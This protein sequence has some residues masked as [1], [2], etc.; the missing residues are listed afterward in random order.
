MTPPRSAHARMT[1]SGFALRDGPERPRPGVRDDDRSR[2]LL[3]R[4]ERRPVAGVGDVDDQPE[5][6][7]APDRAPAE[8]GETGVRALAT[9]GAERVRLRVGDAEHPDAH[10]VQDVD[11][12][13]LVLDRRR[14]L[15]RGDER[16]PALGVGAGDVLRPLAPKRVALVGPVAVAHAHVVDDVRPLPAHLRGDRRDAVLEVLERRIEPRAREPRIARRDPALADPRLRLGRLERVDLQMVVKRDA[17]RRL[18]Q[19]LEPRLLVGAQRDG[20]RLDAV[21]VG[22]QLEGPVVDAGA[23][24][25]ER[26]VAGVRGALPHAAQ[27]IR[28]AEPSGGAHTQDPACDSRY[29]LGCFEPSALC[30]C[31]D[32]G[33]LRLPA[34]SR[35]AP[36]LRMPPR[37]SR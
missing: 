10:A 32:W 26:A 13:E 24:V 31:C 4:L 6:V 2:A 33:S 9:A 16:D 35:P 15:E 14:R 18:D 29:D 25:V 34:H 17:D 23:Q 11:P 1:S 37:R 5:R 27:A 30:R 8:L 3:D 7:H 12:V 28:R 20:L 36:A 19:A 21:E 22:R